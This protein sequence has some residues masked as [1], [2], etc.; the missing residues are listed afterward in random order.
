MRTMRNDNKV[1]RIQEQIYRLSAKVDKISIHNDTFAQSHQNQ[2]IRKTLR[3]CKK[4]LREAEEK[5]ESFEART[6][7]LEEEMEELRMENAILMQSNEKL[8]DEKNQM[9]QTVEELMKSLDDVAEKS[10]RNGD[11]ILVTASE[12]QESA[13]AGIRNLRK[14]IVKERSRYENE[15]DS[16]QEGNDNMRENFDA[17]CS[18]LELCERDFRSAMKQTFGDFE[19]KK[20]MLRESIV[21]E[22][23]VHNDELNQL[24]QDK[25]SAMEKMKA[26]E[27]M[28]TKNMQLM[29]KQVVDVVNGMQQGMEGKMKKVRKAILAERKAHKEEL[30][31]MYYKI[32]DLSTLL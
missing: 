11:Q 24:R 17:L 26:L 4:K 18:K 15:I 22:R 25:E 2:E 21:K 7:K 23:K 13:E 6:L 27:M 8:E 20:K 10:K 32:K 1:D 12:A 5:N 14:V 31:K 9:K 3:K 16:L 29:R 30:R 19:S 28:L